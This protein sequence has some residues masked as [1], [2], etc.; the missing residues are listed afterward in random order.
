MQEGAGWSDAAEGIGEV[1]GLGAMLDMSD[2]VLEKQVSC[3]VGY[4]LEGEEL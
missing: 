3:L 2:A 1:V 4:L